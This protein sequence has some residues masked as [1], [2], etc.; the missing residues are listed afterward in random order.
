[1]AHV[2]RHPGPVRRPVQR[3]RLARRAASTRTRR[4]SASP[5]GC[6]RAFHLRRRSRSPTSASSATR[7]TSAPRRR[8]CSPPRP[9]SA[10]ASRRAARARLGRRRRADPDRPVR[11]DVLG[12]GVDGADGTEW[13]F[14]QRLTLRHRRGRQRHRQPGAEGARRRRHHGPPPPE[15]AA[16]LRLR[17]RLGGAGVL[18]DAQSLAAQSGIPAGNLLLSDRA[19]TYAHNDPAGAY[20]RNAFFAGLIRFLHRV[21]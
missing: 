7:S 16:D 19:S 4:R 2:R 8:A 13:Y 12:L 20:P 6:C 5:P 15:A 9:T 17:A 11:D 1:M 10:G 14:P 21:G 18:F 3:H